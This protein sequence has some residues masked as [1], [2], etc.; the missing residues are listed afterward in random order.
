MVPYNRA[1][2][3]Q[4]AI[5]EPLFYLGL[6]IG[7]ATAGLCRPLRV[8]LVGQRQTCFDGGGQRLI[9]LIDG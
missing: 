5:A 3:T 1:E 2:T 6:H 7:L 9:G 4:G 8:G